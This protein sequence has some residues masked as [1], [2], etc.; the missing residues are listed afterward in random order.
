MAGGLLEGVAPSLHLWA[1]ARIDLWIPHFGIALL[2]NLH[3]PNKI[4]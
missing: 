4:S 1:Y 3:N 2:G